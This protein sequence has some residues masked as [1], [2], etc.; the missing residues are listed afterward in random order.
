MWKK[1]ALYTTFA[2]VAGLLVL[3]AVNRTLARNE[4]VA[5]ENGGGGGANR[6]AVQQGYGHG[7]GNGAGSDSE[8][9]IGGVGQSAEAARQGRGENSGQNL[10]GGGGRGQSAE[11]A[12]QT[13]EWQQVTG[14]VIQ[15]DGTQMTLGL[16]D[17]TDLLVEGMPWQYAQEAGFQAQVGNRL[18]VRGYLE[19]GEFKVGALLNLDGDQEQLQLRNA[20]GQPAWRGQGGGRTGS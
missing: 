10:Q 5:G 3:G 1:I 14:E 2:V 6:T 11:A 19:D 16:A 20:A 8:N 9:A 18:Q 15:V 7:A 13:Y 12:A 17:G 4:L